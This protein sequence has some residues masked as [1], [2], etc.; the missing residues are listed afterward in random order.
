MRPLPRIQRR[1]TAV[2]SLCV[3]ERQ[4][5]GGTRYRL[6]RIVRTATTTAGTLV[7]MATDRYPGGDWRAYVLERPVEARALWDA[8]GDA[9]WESIEDAREAIRPYAVPA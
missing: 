5:I 9:Q 4:V 1:P 6:E 8:L 3:T 7:I 2:G